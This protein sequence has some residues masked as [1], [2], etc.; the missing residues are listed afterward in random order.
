MRPI[1]DY[2][3]Y[4][5]QLTASRGDPYYSSSDLRLSPPLP[6]LSPSPIPTWCRNRCN[7]HACMSTAV[8]ALAAAVAVAKAA[9]TL[10]EVV[11]L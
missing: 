3:G 5:G 9:A 11:G 8:A 7:S 2:T 1:T 10:P 6:P 4:T